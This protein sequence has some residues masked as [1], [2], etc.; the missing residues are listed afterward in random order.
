MKYKVFLVRYASIIVEA[1]SLEDATNKADALIE[2]GYEV[3]AETGWD[4]DFAEKE[5]NE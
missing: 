5:V 2:S 3:S 1:E 4:I